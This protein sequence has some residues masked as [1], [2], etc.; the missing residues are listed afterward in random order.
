MHQDPCPRCAEMAGR[1]ETRRTRRLRCGGLTITAALCI[2]GRL[3]LGGR[4]R[5]RRRVAGCA[6]L[7]LVAG[8]VA[9]DRGAAAL[10]AVGD[11]PARPLE[12]DAHRLEY[13]SHCAATRRTGPQRLVLEGLELLEL[14]TAC[15]T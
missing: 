12:D 5:L 13:P 7:A 10:P 14:S 11:I 4:L 3:A 15:I 2:A 9:A 6:F 8:V 1:L